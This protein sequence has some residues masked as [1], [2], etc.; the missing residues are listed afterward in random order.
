MT[1]AL[2]EAI[3]CKRLPGEDAERRAIMAEALERLGR[4]R[5]HAARR[6]GENLVLARTIHEPAACKCDLRAVRGAVQPAAFLDV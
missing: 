2:R 5:F 3:G 1:V 6:T 4:S